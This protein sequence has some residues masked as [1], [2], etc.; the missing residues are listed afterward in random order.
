MPSRAAVVAKVLVCATTTNGSAPSRT[1]VVTQ[2]RGSQ[3]AT[4]VPLVSPRKK[5]AN[6]HIPAPASSRFDELIRISRRYHHHHT[7]TRMDPTLARI[8]LSNAQWAEAVNAAEPRFFEQSAEGQAP[9]ILWLGCSDSR[10]PESVVT[11][12]RPGDIFVHRNI[13]NQVHPDDDSVL[14]VITYAVGPIG[15]EHILVVGHTNCGGAAACLTAVSTGSS[16]L[17]PATPLSR[18]LAPLTALASTLDLK[19]LPPSEALTKIVEASV[20]AQVENVVN[21]EPVQ[22]AWA[23]DRKNLWVHG[24]VYELETGRLRDLNITRGPPV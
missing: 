14:S 6:R 9:K 19:D 12:S 7:S 17:P 11:A 22:T 13:A 16:P 3:V 10:V 20:R 15:I 18:W 21:S 8:F 4:Q 1:V 24:L 5:T 2:P 23:N